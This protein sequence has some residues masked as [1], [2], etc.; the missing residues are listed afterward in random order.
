MDA[1][2]FISTKHG[3]LNNFCAAPKVCI[4]FKSN[5]HAAEGTGQEAVQIAAEASA[6]EHTAAEDTVEHSAEDT[7]EH[8]VEYTVEH[9]VK[10]RDTVEDTGQDMAGLEPGDIPLI[11]VCSVSFDPRNSI[12]SKDK[13]VSE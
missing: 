12:R 11:H 1:F 8:S 5:V 7:V 6:V 13:A 10:V 3:V 4:V 2:N 9:T